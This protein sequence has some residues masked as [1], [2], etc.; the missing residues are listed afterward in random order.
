MEEIKA[1]LPADAASFALMDAIAI[2][3]SWHLAEGTWAWVCEAAAAFCL[4]LR[5]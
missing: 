4:K 1:R 2:M 5:A 3:F